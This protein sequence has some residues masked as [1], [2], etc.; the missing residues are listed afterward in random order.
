MTAHVCRQ[1]SA[2]VS[3]LRLDRVEGENSGIHV[4]IE[5]L[6]VLDCT[7]GHRR[8]PTPDF[9]LEFI[10]HLVESEAL[11]G[12]TPA[13]QKGLFRKRLHCP[14]CGKELSAVAEDRRNGR[15]HLAVPEGD[16]VAVEVIVPLYRCP[17]CDK[18]ASEPE[19]GL[20][21]DVMQAVANA[22]RSAEIPPG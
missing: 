15:A 4:T 19:S 13:V 10:R 17:A 5:G 21:R 11:D 1:C 16:P 20:Q 8:F 6:P 22:F 7:N 3:V 12:V 9:P 2:D 18:Q 14:A